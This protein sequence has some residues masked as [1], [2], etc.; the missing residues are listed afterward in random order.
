MDGWRHG[1]KSQYQ[2]S[3]VEQ[4]TGAELG[5]V[6]LHPVFAYPVLPQVKLAQIGQGEEE[7]EGLFGEAVS[8]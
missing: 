4:N 8:C 3:E 5:N 1:A 7:R 6:L 2:L